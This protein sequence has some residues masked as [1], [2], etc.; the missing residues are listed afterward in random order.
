MGNIRLICTDVDGT[1]V[2]DD[3]KSIPEANM[4]ALLGAQETGSK[5]AL[6]SGRGIFSQKS[7]IKT[8]GLDRH[9]GYLVAFTGAR[10]V[11]ACGMR[12]LYRMPIGM[13]DANALWAHVRPLG[14]DVMVYDD[15][16]GVIFATA[17]NEYTR[18]DQ[19]VTGMS[20][21]KTDRIDPS[22]GF[23]TF[24]CI[25]AGSPSALDGTIASVKE[26]FS[27]GFEITRSSGVFAEFNKKGVSKGNAMLMLAEEMGIDAGEILAVGN[28]ENDASMLAAA[29]MS[30]APADSMPEAKAAAKYVCRK[31]NGEGALA[32]AISYFNGMRPII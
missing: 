20:F 7:F 2:L 16:R 17:D 6:V 27:E 14:L 25:I 12:E 21:E 28:G 4:E 29:G 8:L 11:E 19:K 23:T 5:L 3:H 22:L 31:G 9:K 1:L 30:A 15:D 24:K 10:I 32:E 18:F 26:K 13:S